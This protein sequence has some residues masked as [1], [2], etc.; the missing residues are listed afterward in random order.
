MFILCLIVSFSAAFI[1]SLF[2]AENAK[3]AWYESVR[4]E[5][6]PP[7]FVFPIVWNILFFLI[8]V[9]LYFAWIN[10]K[11]KEKSKIMVLYGLNFV[12]NICWSFF[13]F[14][15]KNVFFAFIE[16]IFVWISILSIIIYTWKIDRKASYAL[17]PYLLWVSFASVLN[18]LSLK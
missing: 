3:S 11:K 13:Y 1:G 5:I 4:P 14:T 7:N 12:L 8:A 18:F 2:T 6:T 17:I 15:L 9:S 10:S 16:I